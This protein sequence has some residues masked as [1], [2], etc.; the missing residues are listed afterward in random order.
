[1]NVSPIRYAGGKSKAIKK[2]E[3][4]IPGNISCLVSPFFGGGSLEIHIAK[5]RGIKVY[6]YDI[7]NILVM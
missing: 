7:F 5:T 6:G 3:P 1:M 4:Y 2:I